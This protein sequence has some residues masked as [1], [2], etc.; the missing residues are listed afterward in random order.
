MKKPIPFFRRII[1]FIIL[2]LLFTHTYSQP[3][4]FTWQNRHKEW[5]NPV[6]PAK[7]QGLNGPCSIF[8]AVA[9][10]EAMTSIYY[11]LNDTQIILSESSIYNA[12]SNEGCVGITCGTG[13]VQS[14]LNIMNSIGIVDNVN[15]PYQSNCRDDCQT[16]FSSQ[17]YNYKIKIPK[18]TGSQITID[19]A[20]ALQQAIMDYGP[21]IATLGGN[22]GGYYVTHY[23][24]P[25][26]GINTDHSVLI[27]GWRHNPELEWHIKDSWHEKHSIYYRSTDSIDIFDFGPSFYR[28]HP[29][30][31]SN[32][33]ISCA[34]DGCPGAISNRIPE[35][36][37]GDGFYNWGIGLK[38]PNFPGIVSNMDVDDGDKKV[39]FRDGYNI[40]A[41][42]YISDTI[43]SKY[44]CSGGKTFTLENFDA[45]SQRGFTV[46]WNLSPSNYFSSSSGSSKTA[47]VIP[48]SSYYGK[49]CSL[50]YHLYKGDT[51]VTTH[52][53]EFY[54]NGP[55]E[56]HVSISVL[57]SHGGSPTKYGDTYYLCPNTNYTISYNNYDDSCT[58][59]N[60]SWGLPY[61]WSKNWEYNNQVSI[62]TNNNPDGFLSISAL[63]SYCNE[64]IQV[65]NPYFGASE[66]GEYFVLYPNPAE[67]FVV[68]DIM[69]DKF[70]SEKISY[71]EDCTLTIMDKVGISKDIVKFKGFPYTLDTSKLKEGLYFVIIQ[72]N[73]IRATLQL[74]INP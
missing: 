13:D 12:G 53:Y 45:L 62:N 49:K 3:S 41:G 22:Y 24:Y 2:V 14:A 20:V 51:L 68:V 73:D 60:F 37:D 43:H 18:A 1:M 9:G 44:I 57:D 47:N 35:D 70:S 11:L 38:P 25:E 58:T 56:D 5:K 69:K 4:S 10:V 65:L 28:V 72:L 64:N 63:T 29:L 59:S 15:Y 36:H 46:N 19:S 17:N 39:I 8:A 74:V 7:N 52:K 67:S 40:L 50:E 54:I 6:S 32:N 33:P 31:N 21:I 42:P 71:E 55:R 26:S 16:V 23:L 61:G 34:G 66:C 27:I 48:Y 30:D